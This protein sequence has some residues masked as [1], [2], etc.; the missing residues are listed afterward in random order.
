MKRGTSGTQT[1]TRSTI[2]VG[3]ETTAVSRWKLV[4]RV[5]LLCAMPFPKKHLKRY[6]LHNLTTLSWH[7]YYPN[8]TGKE[9]A[10]IH[11]N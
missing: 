2:C 8:F 1:Q 9:M 3:K 4:F 6:F 10:V 5:C 7:N 11:L